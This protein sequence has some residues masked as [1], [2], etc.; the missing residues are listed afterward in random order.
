L[1]F[2]YTGGTL[3]VSNLVVEKATS[4]GATYAGV[5]TGYTQGNATLTNITVKE[6]N[7]SGVKKIGGISGFVEASTTNF[8]AE[9]C[10][11][12]DT[13]VAATEKQAG[14]IIGYNA[15]PATLKNCTVENSTATAPQYCDGGVR[16]TDLAQAELTIE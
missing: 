9:N 3:N 14:T 15:K 12:I 4:V 7:I 6:C 1:F 5:I 10:K 2:C 8:V 16:C 13:T 11:V